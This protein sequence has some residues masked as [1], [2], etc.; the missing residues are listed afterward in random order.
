MFT[1][2]EREQAKQ[3]IESLYTYIEQFLQL[4]EYTQDLRD[5]LHKSYP[6]YF[7]VLKKRKI[8]VR[9]EQGIVIAGTVSFFLAN[10]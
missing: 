2:E 7:E 6:S 8:D 3:R 1:L 5:E 4:D 10:N 9:K